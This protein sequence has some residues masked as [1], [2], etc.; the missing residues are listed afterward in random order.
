MKK[1]KVWARRP[2]ERGKKREHRERAKRG[3][4]KRESMVNIAGF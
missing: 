4:E 3:R 2:G 1:E